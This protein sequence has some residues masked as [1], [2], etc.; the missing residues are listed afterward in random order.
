MLRPCS[1]DEFYKYADFAYE[2]AC[3]LTKSGYPT[4]CDGVKTKAMFID[5]ALKAF[6]RETEQMLLFEVQGRV[7][8][9]IHC[10]WI[11][12]DHYLDTVSFNV[13]E[14]MEQALAEFLTFAAARFKGY[15]LFLG[16]PAENQAAVN[17]LAERGFECIEDDY[18]NIALLEKL[19]N[20][21]AASGLHR[22]GRENYESFRKLHCQIEGDMYWNSDRILA[23]LDDWVIFVKEENGS[24]R[25]AVYYMD[26][27]D[28]WFEIFGVDLDGMAHAPGLLKEL[29]RAALLD[30]KRRGGKVMSFFCE[31]EDEE[32]ALECGFTCIGNYRCYKASLE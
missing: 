4:Y 14:A 9:L 23:N 28:G 16:F 1:E 32:A 13:N 30:A 31:R 11:P 6:E 24:P 7:Q 17:F 2:L 27:R 25:G 15:E 18:N 19:E 29:V 8:G 20:V 26:S 22:V 5:R 3:D 10:Y 12:E 21:P